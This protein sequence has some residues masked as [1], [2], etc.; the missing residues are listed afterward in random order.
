MLINDSLK[1]KAFQQQ[2]ENEDLRQ[3]LSYLETI[4]GRDSTSISEMV[5]AESSR[6]DWARLLLDRDTDDM[7]ITVSREKIAHELI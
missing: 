7:I 6:V 3:R 4:A 1:T 2:L 5:T